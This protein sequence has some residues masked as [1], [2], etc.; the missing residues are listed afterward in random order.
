M[1]KLRASLALVILSFLSN[2]VFSQ[3]GDPNAGPTIN[4]GGDGTTTTLGSLLGNRIFPLET[5]SE[6][7]GSPY[8]LDSFTNCVITTKKGQKYAYN[9]MRMNLH[10]QKIHF[11]DKNNTELV[12]DDDV[13]TRIV[14]L[15][16]GVDTIAG[17]AFSCNYPAIG[18]NNSLTYYLEVNSGRARMLQLI[19]KDVGS[20]NMVT[21]QVAKKEFKEHK[22]Y[23][24]YNENHSKM[25]RFKKGKESVL[26]LLRDKKDLVEKFINDNNLNC[27]SA[28]D[29]V[30]VFDYYNSLK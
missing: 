22:E 10:S 27:K 4:I 20:S 16:Q 7:S 3:P 23:F 17:F 5:Y 28:E 18:K 2:S 19:S 21:G 25:E 12:V 11:L 1:S 9:K 14:F 15:K 26:D 29:V 8:F 30:K 6:V 13:I 24:M